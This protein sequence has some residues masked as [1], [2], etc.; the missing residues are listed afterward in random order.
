MIESIDGKEEEG[1]EKERT[2]ETGCLRSGSAVAP[3]TVR[4]KGDAA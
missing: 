3:A 1:K 2:G 4:E